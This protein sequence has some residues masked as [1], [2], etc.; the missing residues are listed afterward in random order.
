MRGL[1]LATSCCIWLLVTLLV[2][3]NAFVV[4]V[5][6]S[7]LGRT[8]PK[9]ASFQFQPPP[10]VRRAVSLLEKEDDDIVDNFDAE[11]FGGYLAPYALAAVASI[12]VTAAFFKFVLLDY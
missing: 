4:P 10:A 1:S 11:G 9:C 5:Q 6:Q 12:L 7:T 2:S 8:V 3:V